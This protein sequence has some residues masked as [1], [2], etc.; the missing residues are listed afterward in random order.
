MIRLRVATARQGGLRVKACSF[1]PAVGV[2][3][4]LHF[5]N[6]VQANF[7]YGVSRQAGILRRRKAKPMR[8]NSKREKV[9]PAAAFLLD[10]NATGF[11]GKH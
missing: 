1:P 2:R 3:V 11:R 8:E 4:A 6:P 10:Y 7:D 5:G 9:V